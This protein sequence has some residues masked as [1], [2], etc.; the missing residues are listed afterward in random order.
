[1][2]RKTHYHVALLDYELGDM[3]GLALAKELRRTNEEINI[4]LMTAHASL[5]M[6]VKA[7]QA[8]VYDYLIKPIDSNQFKRS[9]DNALEK[10]RL[11]LE[12]KRLLET[13]KKRTAELVRMSEQ[14]SRFFHRF[15][16]FALS[17]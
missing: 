10:N 11:T 14:K 6:A 1:M 2:P 16:R 17:P 8:D 5:D 4:I 3:T 9:L 15:P 7:I 13:S 12:N